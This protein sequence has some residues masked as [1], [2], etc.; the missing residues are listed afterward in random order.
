DSIKGDTVS[1]VMKAAKVSTGL[2]IKVPMFI[3]EGDKVRVD[4]RT[5]EY[6]ERYTEP[7]K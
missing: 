5:T 2:E 3:K 4:T 1:N 7:K 6:V